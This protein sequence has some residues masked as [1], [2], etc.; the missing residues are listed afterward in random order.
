MSELRILDKVCEVR[1]NHYHINE[2]VVEIAEEGPEDSDDITTRFLFREY[3]QTSQ[4][5]NAYGR[6]QLVMVACF[7]SQSEKFIQIAKALCSRVLCPFEAVASTSIITT[8]QLLLERGSRWVLRTRLPSHHPGA[9]G[10]GVEAE[11]DQ[12]AKKKWKGMTIKWRAKNQARPLEGCLHGFTFNGDAAWGE[13]TRLINGFITGVGQV[14]EKADEGLLHDGGILSPTAAAALSD[15]VDA[16]E[17][18]WRM[19]LCMRDTMLR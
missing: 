9:R 8:G 14:P 15:G 7:A 6:P 16:V 4:N 10:E 17:P 1:F 18:E 11:E 12:V 19:R 13:V 3:D 5:E 2:L